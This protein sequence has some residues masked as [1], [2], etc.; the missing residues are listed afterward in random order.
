MEA[1]KLQNKIVE[2]I[3]LEFNRSKLIEIIINPNELLRG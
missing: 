2:Y 1:C 3:H